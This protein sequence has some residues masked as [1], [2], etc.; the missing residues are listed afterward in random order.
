M[1]RFLFV[2][3]PV[4]ILLLAGCGSGPK[5]YSVT[6][7]VTY[8]G[9]PVEGAD[10][11]FLPVKEDPTVKPAGGATGAGGKFTVKTYFAPGDERTGATAGMYKITL[12]KFPPVT[13]IADPY[14]PGPQPKNELPGKYS[15]NL[16]TPLEREVKASGRNDFVLELAD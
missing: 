7:T 2:A 3:A 4:A 10:I 1:V 11:A 6:G 14:K 16:T 5:T 15:S 13:G 9:A 8:K 12:Q